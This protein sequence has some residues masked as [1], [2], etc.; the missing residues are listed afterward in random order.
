MN[1]ISSVMPAMSKLY[2]DMPTR[3]VKAVAV[4]YDQVNEIADKLLILSHVWTDD[5]NK[6]YAAFPHGNAPYVLKN[7]ATALGKNHPLAKKILE[8]L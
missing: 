2:E 7:I 4:T 3:A 8:I 5:V 6:L 1:R